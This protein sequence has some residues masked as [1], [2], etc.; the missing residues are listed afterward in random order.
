M[1]RLILQ[2]TLDIDPHDGPILQT[3]E[4]RPGMV[5]WLSEVMRLTSRGAGMFDLGGLSPT[6]HGL[7]L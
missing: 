2:P 5:N 4:L 3:R 6:A 1:S 7:S